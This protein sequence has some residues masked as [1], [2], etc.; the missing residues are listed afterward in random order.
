[1]ARS[2]SLLRSALATYE[3]RIQSDPAARQAAVLVPLT[4]DPNDLQ[5]LCFRRTDDVLEHRGEICFPGGA[6]E[7]IDGSFVH[8]ALR[9]TSEE[10]GL[11][12]SAVEVLGMLDDVHTTVSNYIITPVVGYVAGRLHLTLDPLE[13]AELISVPIARLLESGVAAEIATH[14]HGSGR[15]YVFEF[16]GHRI[17]GATARIL[18]SLLDLWPAAVPSA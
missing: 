3:R 5:L 12:P 11:A 9:E 13:V 6:R 7:A 15:R 14:E 17:W 8:T 4:G 2:L 16:D 18:R 1:M 10:L